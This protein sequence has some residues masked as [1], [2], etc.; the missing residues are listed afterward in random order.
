MKQLLSP[1]QVAR[2]LQVSESSVKRWC[3][4]GV[5]QSARTAGGHR[6]ISV[7]EVMR[8][9]RLRD[10]RVAHPDILGL[11][12]SRGHSPRALD[13]AAGAL[14]DALVAGS[15]PRCS[16]VLLDLYLGNHS[17]AAIGDRVIATAFH[18][19]GEAW[20]CGRLEIYQ[21]RQGCEIAQR[22]LHELRLALPEP[23]TDAP[24]AIG[25]TLENDPYSLASLLV[26]LVLRQMGWRTIQLGGG[27]PIES[28]LHA[29]EH[30][31]PQLVWI[32]ISA[33]DDS[34]QF[35]Q[36]H[37]YLLQQM[38]EVGRLVMGGRAINAEMV[39]RLNAATYCGNLE[40]LEN[41][42][43]AVAA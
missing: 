10:F 25:G 34:E 41:K 31:Q 9:V 6:K 14:F 36:H 1:R 13:R 18:H 8:F 15:L 27:L 43:L 17:L 35:I 7:G 3:D 28:V 39:Q 32:S 2:A 33:L 42:L 24:L 38:A 26:E 23:R 19:L 30:Y 21:E 5:I 22:A 37:S 20:E 40:E 12:A 29:V 11:P 16:E 4:E